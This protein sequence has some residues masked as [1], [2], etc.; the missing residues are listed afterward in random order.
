MQLSDI[1]IFMILKSRI[2]VEFAKPVIR[3]FLCFRWVF[4]DKCG[5]VAAADLHDILLECVARIDGFV[6]HAGPVVVDRGGGIV[7]ELGDAGT[8]FDAE[9][10]EGEDA[11]LGGQLLFSLGIDSLFGAQQLV[12]AIYEVGE[13]SKEGGVEVGVEFLKVFGD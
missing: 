7:E 10:D 9:A 3:G 11:Q 6:A 8:F 5:G 1:H 13:D 2:N 12:E 4:V